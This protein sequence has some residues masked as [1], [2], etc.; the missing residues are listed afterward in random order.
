MA[1]VAALESTGTLQQTH[2]SHCLW[3][4]DCPGELVAP[5]S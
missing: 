3:A 1:R 5:A 4:F 2:D